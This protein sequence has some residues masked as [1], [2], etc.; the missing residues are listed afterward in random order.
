MVHIRVFKFLLAL[1]VADVQNIRL[2][3]SN[4]TIPVLRCLGLWPRW[5]RN[6]NRRLG[7]HFSSGDSTAL[8]FLPNE[9]SDLLNGSH[10]PIRLAIAGTIKMIAVEFIFPTLK[11]LG[12]SSRGRLAIIVFLLVVVGVPLRLVRLSFTRWRL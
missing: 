6:D 3:G 11:L 7:D 8:V 1:I 5:H 2:D 12:T 4:I 9:V 10:V